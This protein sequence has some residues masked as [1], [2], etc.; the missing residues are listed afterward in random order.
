MTERERRSCRV[1]Q[2]LARVSSPSSESADCSLLACHKTIK[3]LDLGCLPSPEFLVFLSDTF[4]SSS[5]PADLEL[6][7]TTAGQTRPELVHFWAPRLLLAIQP[8]VYY[9]PLALIAH[10]TDFPS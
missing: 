7:L 8:I 4:G 6:T 10:R 9:G 2:C 5:T 1:V 3:Y